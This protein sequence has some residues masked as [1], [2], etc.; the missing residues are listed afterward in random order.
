LSLLR[1]KLTR[2]TAGTP[3][4]VPIVPVGS[5][6]LQTAIVLFGGVVMPDHGPGKIIEP[7]EMLQMGDLARRYEESRKRGNVKATKVK[8]PK[9]TKDRLKSYV[10]RDPSD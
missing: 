4:P 2:R 5:N 8:T 9:G 3:E 7:E 6:F 1:D 10:Y